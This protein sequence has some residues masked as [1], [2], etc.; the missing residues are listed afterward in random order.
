MSLTHARAIADFPN[1]NDSDLYRKIDGAMIS[2]ELVARAATFAYFDA[3]RSTK[4][5]EAIEASGV[6]H[7][8][9]APMTNGE[10]A[11]YAFGLFREA[12]AGYA[13]HRIKEYL[14]TYIELDRIR[15]DVHSWRLDPES[16]KKAVGWLEL[17]YNTQ[18]DRRVFGYDPSMLPFGSTTV[19]VSDAIKGFLDFYVLDSGIS[20]RFRDSKNFNAMVSDIMRAEW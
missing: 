12:C 1:T 19:P 18:M 8:S 11:H 9:N 5:V 13:G 20:D 16:A 10:S 4:V 15:I 17:I 2:V 14:R 3:Y 7:Y 6:A